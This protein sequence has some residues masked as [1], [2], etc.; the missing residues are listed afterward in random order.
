MSVGSIKSR[1]H[2]RRLTKMKKQDFSVFKKIL[3]GV[4]QQHKADKHHERGPDVAA[5]VGLE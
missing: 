4:D 3:L 2:H 1:N 5:D